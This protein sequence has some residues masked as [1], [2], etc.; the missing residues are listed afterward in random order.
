MGLRKYFELEENT[1]HDLS[2]LHFSH[3][4]K[5]KSSAKLV[6]SQ[7]V[8]KNG[9]KHCQYSSTEEENSLS[10][11][12]NSTSYNK[13]SNL[14]FYIKSDHLNQKKHEILNEGIEK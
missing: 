14:H 6:P 9:D 1:S 4:N 5:K 10:T 3:G 11:C 7:T 2:S 13:S 12:Q 8:D